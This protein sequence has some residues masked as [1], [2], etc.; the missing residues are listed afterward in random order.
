MGQRRQA[1]T[2]LS[3]RSV[4]AQFAPAFSGDCLY[5]LAF[6]NPDPL[7]TGTGGHI[8][9]VGSGRNPTVQHR[10]YREDTDR[11]LLQEPA[12]ALPRMWRRVVADR[13]HNRTEPQRR[14]VDDIGQPV[15]ARR[16]LLPGPHKSQRL[17]TNLP[18]TIRNGVNRPRSSNLIRRYIGTLYG[19][20]DP[21]IADSVLRSRWK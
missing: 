10:R 19:Y 1:A 20:P 17:S 14:I 12:F 21:R 18:H 11:P 6:G 2:M 15:V 9:P 16:V 3:W 5:R 8:A 13:V 4:G 7:L